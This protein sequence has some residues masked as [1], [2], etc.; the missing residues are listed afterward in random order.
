[1]FVCETFP[2][3][4]IT[5]HI[6]LRGLNRSYIDIKF[7]VASAFSSEKRT[8]TEL[9]KGMEALCCS[10][11]LIHIQMCIRDRCKL[12]MC[13]LLCA[14]QSFDLHKT[15]KTLCHKTYFYI[16]VLS[17]NKELFGWPMF[18]S[19]VF[20]FLNANLQR[21]FVI[22]WV[23]HFFI[24]CY[25]LFYILFYY[26]SFEQFC[27]FF[28]TVV[29]NVNVT[30]FYTLLLSMFFLNNFAVYISYFI[31]YFLQASSTFV[32]QFSSAIQ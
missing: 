19:F 1:M 15:Y 21:S 23:I 10:L 29:T 26:L 28:D 30:Q 25:Y 20:N 17:I 27:N 31:F 16:V 22:L 11:S 5:L 7:Q 3:V 32:C 13:I 2:T 9:M 18:Q 12:Q 4:H 24:Y 14:E 8:S 6:I